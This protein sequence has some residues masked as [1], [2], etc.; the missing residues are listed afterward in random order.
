MPPGVA[1]VAAA[2]LRAEDGAVDGRHLPH[3]Q[4]REQRI[5]AGDPQAW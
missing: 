1:R 3:G 5:R 2:R 4:L